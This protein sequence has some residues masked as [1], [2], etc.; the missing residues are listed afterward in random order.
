MTTLYPLL[1]VGFPA[2]GSTEYTRLGNAFGVTPD[3]IRM[4]ASDF[5]SGSS[6]RSTT[7]TS[8]ALGTGCASCR[9]TSTY[10]SATEN[11]EARSGKR[12]WRRTTRSRIWS[13]SSA[14][15]AFPRRKGTSTASPASNR[16]PTNRAF[17]WEVHDVDGLK[18]TE[19]LDLS[20]RQQR[21]VRIDPRRDHRPHRQGA[22]ASPTWK[23]IRLAPQ[24]AGRWRT[25][26]TRQG[27]LRRKL[28][29]QLRASHQAQRF[30]QHLSLWAPVCTR[31]P[32]PLSDL[33][34]EGHP[35]VVGAA[36]DLRRMVR[37]SGAPPR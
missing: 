25:E 24:L 5:S 21:P 29:R 33:I 31:W 34:D 7:G 19:L 4:P 23:Q 36:V 17:G 15:R 11:C 18:C 14:Q 28:K 9:Q 8:M 30:H 37:F 12:R 16:W 35:I 27:Y 32:T 26:S 13:R 22:R 2:A 6:G 10:C 3:A 1:M 20:H